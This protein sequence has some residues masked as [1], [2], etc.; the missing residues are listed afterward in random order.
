MFVL[1]IPTMQLQ[2]ELPA[3]DKP[4]IFITPMSAGAAKQLPVPGAAGRDI[5]DADEGRKVH[6]VGSYVA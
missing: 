2:N 6:V 5:V 3:V 4:L 1:H